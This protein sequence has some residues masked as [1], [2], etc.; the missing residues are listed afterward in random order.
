MRAFPR[1][2]KSG[3]GVT[4]VEVLVA[5]GL[6][7]LAM[8]MLLNIYVSGLKSWEQT[9]DESQLLTSVRQALYLMTTELRNATRTSTQNPSPN[10]SIPSTPN[11]KSIQFYVPEDKNGD[12]LLTDANGAIEW[13][14]NNVIQYQYV[15]GQRLLRRLEKGVQRTIADDVSD[16][17]FIDR[18]I[19]PSLSM[20]E[21]RIVL[22]LSMTT[23]R[24]RQL[25][26]TRTATVRLRN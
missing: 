24:Q 5:S 23:D 4:M 6:L 19:D 7:A 9:R 25:T 20:T 2:S 16:I 15:P 13:G 8:A 26:V 10:L 22:T 21:L 11:N 14:T 12:G 17:Q 1:R 18:T 3:A